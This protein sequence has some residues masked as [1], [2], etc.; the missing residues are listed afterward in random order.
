VP[1]FNLAITAF[2]CAC[3]TYKRSLLVQEQDMLNLRSLRAKK[4]RL[5]LK[6]SGSGSRVI[7]IT[8]LGLAVL[9]ALLF[10]ASLDRMPI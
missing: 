6:L 3:P 10:F 4:A 9:S 5:A 2:Y 1:G 8:M 7:I